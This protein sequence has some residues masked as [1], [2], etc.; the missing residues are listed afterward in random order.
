MSSR[1]T[2]F[3]L[4]KQFQNDGTVGRRPGNGRKRT[5]TASEG[6]YLSITARRNMK[7]TARQLSSQLAAA[8]GTVKLGVTRSKFIK[9]NQDEPEYYFCC[10]KLFSG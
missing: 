3:T 10:M 6:R 7:S 9:E 2:V 4:R 1:Q 5:T 8:T